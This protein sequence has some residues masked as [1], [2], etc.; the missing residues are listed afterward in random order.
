MA[1]FFPFAF[2]YLLFD[3]LFRFF[4]QNLVTN[5]RSCMNFLFFFSLIGGRKWLIFVYITSRLLIAPFAI[6]SRKKH[7][8]IW[9]IQFDIITSNGLFC[10]LALSSMFLLNFNILA[11]SD[12]T[13]NVNTGIYIAQPPFF[14]F[15]DSL[16]NS[17]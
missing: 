4:H 16:W 15:V 3:F 13:N 12:E 11:R 1:E 8:P 2:I 9:N 10:V 6:W 14:F 17:A 7:I 5:I